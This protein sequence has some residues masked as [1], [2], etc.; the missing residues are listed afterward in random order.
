M[1]TVVGL[2]LVCACAPSRHH[3]IA[4]PDSAAERPAMDTTRPDPEPTAPA[5]T[6]EQQ[7]YLRVDSIV[8]EPDPIEL[9]RGE[10]LPLSELRVTMLDDAGRPVE[11]VPF[12]TTLMSGIAGLVEDEIRTHRAGEAELLFWL[13]F[14]RPE[15]APWRSVLTRV[16]LIVRPDPVSHIR[17][18]APERI[19]AG[20]A[21]SLSLHAYTAEGDARAAPEPY[22]ASADPTIARVDALGFVRG[23]SPGKTRVTAEFEGVRGE[24]T[25]EVVANPVR[26]LVLTPSERTVRVG[27]VVR[28]QAIARDAAGGT[29]ESPH[30]LFTASGGEEWELG[31]ASVYDDGAFVAGL[32]GIY[33]VVA[34]SGSV[35]TSA[36]IRA[37]RRGIEM[38]ALLVGQGLDGERG[39]SDIWVFEGVDGRDYAYLGG[40]GVYAWDVTDPA[41]PVLTDSVMKDGR[42]VNDVKV[43]ADAR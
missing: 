21:V 33:R 19:Y 17:I 10:S 14:Q 5:L 9:R 27:D 36:V 32:P 1:L 16:P 22:W 6:A 28:F 38:D 34:T 41:K 37:E 43:T 35:S 8:I 23:E 11:S 12:E 3:E 25:I 40:R 7:A 31:G 15:G 26:T 18:E 42:W 29:I 13:S 4:T 2:V 20:A 39:A 30:I 24:A